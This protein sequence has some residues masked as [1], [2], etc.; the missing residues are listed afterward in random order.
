MIIDKEAVVHT[1][2]AWGWRAAP[3]HR[4]RGII[5]VGP[6]TYE[7]TFAGEAGS[8]VRAE[9]DDC[10]VSVGQGL[11]T[12]RVELPDQGALWEILQRIIDLGLQVIHM[13][14]VAS[15]PTP[16][17]ER[18]QTV[19]CPG[20]GRAADADLSRLNMTSASAGHF[21]ICLP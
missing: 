12:L 19:I 10:E 8:A 11:T 14:L 20:N 1:P 6:H 15:P 4:L 13:H 21:L 5:R 18:A 9:F 7:I 17:Q 2:P 16:S 3:D